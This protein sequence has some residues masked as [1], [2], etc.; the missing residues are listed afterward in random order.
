MRPTASSITDDQLDA[1]Y[2]RLD[3]QSRA[4]NR[5]HALAESWT[6]HQTLITRD[7][8]ARLLDQVLGDGWM[9][10]APRPVGDGHPELTEILAEETIR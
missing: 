3:K 7:G 2:E 1:L 5:A 10:I 6:G 8:A 4:L 9:Q